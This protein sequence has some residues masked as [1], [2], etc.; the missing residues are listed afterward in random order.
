[1]RCL[2]ELDLSFAQSGITT[3]II[4]VDNAS[5]DGSR[6][7]LA[8]WKPQHATHYSFIPQE[9]NVGFSRGNNVGLRR[10][11]GRAIL[12]LNSDVL[13]GN[14]DRAIVWSNLLR[15]LFED[16]A[17]AGLTVQVRLPNGSIDPASHRGFPTPLRSLW[18][19]LG[20]ERFAVMTNILLFKRLFGGYHLVH[21]DL[22]RPHVVEACTA[23]FFL[24]RGDVLRTLQGFDEEFF[25]YGEDLDLCFR[26]HASGH[27][28]WWTPT[29]SVTHLKYQSGLGSQTPQTKRLITRAFFDAM[30]IFYRKNY[31][32]KYGPVVSHLVRAGISLLMFIKTKRF[33]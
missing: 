20:F 32:A 23:A 2:S 33:T 7:K 16:V 8:E 1:M 13:V 25:M 22:H 21:S 18:Y 30:W 17:R 27:S 4:V 26:M 19:F 10:A 24:V 5:T 15:E 9:T 31:S 6:E 11:T 14:T 29:Y 3:E 12:Y 28:I